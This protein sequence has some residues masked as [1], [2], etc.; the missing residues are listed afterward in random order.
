MAQTVGMRTSVRFG[1][2][3][4]DLVHERCDIHDEFSPVTIVARLVL[5]DEPIQPGAH[6]AVLPHSLFID[7]KHTVAGVCAHWINPF[8]KRSSVRGFFGKPRPL[9]FCRWL[10]GLRAFTGRVL[11]TYGSGA[12]GFS[13]R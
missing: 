5:L 6:A 3:D 4:M 9:I 13:R 7:A 12:L 1:D 2:F 8:G 11:R 10:R